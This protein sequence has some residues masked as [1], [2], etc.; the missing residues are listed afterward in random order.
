MERFLR[1]RV[2][3]KPAHKSNWP[4]TESAR[5]GLTKP[6]VTLRHALEPE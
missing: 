3:V 4:E 2:T 1:Y 5:Q 6:L